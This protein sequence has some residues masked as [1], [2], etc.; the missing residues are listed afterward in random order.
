MST[1][2]HRVRERNA[3]IYVVFDAMWH[4]LFDNFLDC[5]KWDMQGSTDYSQRATFT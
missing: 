1:Q 4:F 3:E 2:G 5:S